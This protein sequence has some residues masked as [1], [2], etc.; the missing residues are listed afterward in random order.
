MQCNARL[1]DI[2]RSHKHKFLAFL[3]ICVHGH[4]RHARGCPGNHGR[5][6][7]RA[8]RIPLALHARDALALIEVPA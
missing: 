4:P 3:F 2:E 1:V 8:H 5:G 7:G 6:R